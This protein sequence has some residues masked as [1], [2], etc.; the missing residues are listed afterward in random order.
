MRRSQY[1]LPRL[2][3]ELQRRHGFL[4]ISERGTVVFVGAAARE[5][6]RDVGLARVVP[7]VL[8]QALE[9]GRGRDSAPRRR[10][11]RARIG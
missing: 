5:R 9:R 2:C 3:D 8:P 10:S 7:E 6:D 1:A 4:D 11:E